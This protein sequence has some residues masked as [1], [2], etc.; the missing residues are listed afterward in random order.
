MSRTVELYLV[1][2]RC[3]ATFERTR[4]KMVHGH[5]VIDRCVI[6]W[7]CTFIKKRGASASVVKVA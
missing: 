5:C 1:F 4:V 6:K 2:Y 7:P 3:D